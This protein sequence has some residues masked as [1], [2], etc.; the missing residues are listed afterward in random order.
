[1]PIIRVMNWN[2]EQLSWNSINI[3]GMAQALARTIA[4][5]NVDIAVLLEVKTTH[6]EN[7]MA[8]L[9]A[10]LNALPGVAGNPWV[11]FLSH[12]TGVEYYGFL[13]RNLNLIRPLAY[14]PAAGVAL[15]DQTDGTSEQPFDDL[16]KLAW[17]TWPFNWGAAVPALAP[18]R[19]R[20][21]LIRFFA[22]PWRSRA[23]KKRKMDF[24]GERHGEAGPTG[25]GYAETNRG[26]RLPCLAIFHVH[27]PAAGGAAAGDYYIPVVVCH[28]GA[29]RKGRNGLAQH[30]VDH[31]HLMHI[32]QL[33]ST[34]DVAGPGIPESGNLDID[35]AQRTVRE[36]MF[37]GDFNLDFLMNRNAG[38]TQ[39][40]R[41]N[42]RAYLRLTPTETGGGSGLPAAAAGAVPALGAAP[43]AIREAPDIPF[44][45]LK[46][47]VTTQGTML[48]KLPAL[49]P[50]VAAPPVGAAF[51]NFL[52]GGD[53]LSQAVIPG[54]GAVDAGRVVDVP[55]MIVQGAPAAIAQ[56]N[57]AAVHNHYRTAATNHAHYPQADPLG[58]GPAPLGGHPALTPAARWIGA[59]FLSDHLPVVLEFNCP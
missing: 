35:G 52:Y 37:T 47:A 34:H 54:G 56:I 5:Q 31:L 4:S 40:E 45:E 36:L 15:D 1:M 16:G 44:Q 32:P 6:V 51:D 38:A 33:F 14:A 18:A 3:P 46:A 22:Q 7:V 48:A 26:Y 43:L 27:T 30:Q 59:R 55:A 10:T 25:S 24:G 8:L 58:G 29:A 42:H 23:A 41:T 50:A 19:P 9:T 28:Y 12:P 20:M 11:W 17:T 13:V 2:I 21:G 57:L 39:E 53:R 49:M